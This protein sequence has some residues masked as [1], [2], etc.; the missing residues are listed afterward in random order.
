MA[1]TCQKYYFPKIVHLILLCSIVS[2]S[3]TNTEESSD[4][5]TNRIAEA[6]QKLLKMIQK[7]IKE[8]LIDRFIYLQFN[9]SLDAVLFSLNCF[10]GKFVDFC[11]AIRRF[12]C[13]SRRKSSFFT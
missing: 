13:Y 12:S 10:S 9:N 11:I 7:G 2:S 5:F 3:S 4:I 1:L 8:H 6:K